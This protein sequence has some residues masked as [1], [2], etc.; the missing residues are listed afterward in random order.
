V[1][2]FPNSPDS[3][4]RAI[5]ASSATRKTSALLFTPIAV[6]FGPRYRFFWQT[7]LVQ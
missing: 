2:F 6:T 7:G 5:S 4:L 3:P 1:F